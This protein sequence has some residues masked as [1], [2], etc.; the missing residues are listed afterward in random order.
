MPPTL[1]SQVS[2]VSFVFF[3]CNLTCIYIKGNS[4]IAFQN[5]ILQLK[6]SK[7]DYEYVEII[8]SIAHINIIILGT[9]T[10]T[11]YFDLL[12]TYSVKRIFETKSFLL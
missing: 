12:E 6:N 8:D 4:F 5:N 9:N 3:L 2:F 7:D 11:C 10:D 1:N